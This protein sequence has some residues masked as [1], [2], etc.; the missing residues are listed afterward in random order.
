M[1]GLIRPI[2]STVSSIILVTLFLGG[3]AQGAD[4]PLLLRNP[5][6]SRDKIA[7]L[8]AS[9]V[10]IVAREGGEARRLTSVNSV[11]NGPYYS[12]DGAQIAYSTSEHGLTDVYVV[13]ADGGV[14]RRRSSAK[15]TLC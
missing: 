9:D 6:L 5:S 11:V 7:F 2:F 4:S 10:W 14:P 1:Y 15:L 3:T 8:Y 12:P 13:N